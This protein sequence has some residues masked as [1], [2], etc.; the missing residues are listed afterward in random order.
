MAGDADGDLAGNPDRA[1][2]QEDEAAIHGDTVNELLDN[3]PRR[4]NID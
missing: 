3:P 1:D 2:D 4:T